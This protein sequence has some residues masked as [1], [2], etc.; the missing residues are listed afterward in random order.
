MF[1]KIFCSV[2][3]VLLSSS[4]WA[5][6]LNDLQTLLQQPQNIKGHFTQ[7]RYLKSMK[8]PVAAQ[9]EFL[10]VPNAGLLWQM[11]KPFVDSMRIR[12]S[13][14][15]QLNAQN[16]WVASKQSASAQ[17][18][19][20]KL[21]LNLLAGQTSG[22]QSQFNLKLQGNAKNWHLQ[23]LPKTMLMKQIFTRIDIQGDS[24]V[25]KIHLYE[26][27]GDRTEIAFTDIKMNIR[28]NQFEQNAV[29]P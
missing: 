27:Q 20:V 7:L 14:I 23:L 2:V 26:T 12:K 28:L 11:K 3:L 16:K 18:N 19:Q 10:L 15:E 9:G 21:F 13:G 17:K 29:L 6:N 25:R 24:L 22:L 5:F 4:I 1:K 8:K